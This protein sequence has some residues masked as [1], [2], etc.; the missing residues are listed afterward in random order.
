MNFLEGKRV[1]EVN[2]MAEFGTQLAHVDGGV[3]NI[4]GTYLS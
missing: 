4:V 1:D 2:K 3:P